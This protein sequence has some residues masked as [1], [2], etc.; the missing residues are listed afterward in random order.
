MFKKEKR[1]MQN[2]ILPAIKKN[3]IILFFGWTQRFIILSEVSYRE[4]STI[5]T[6]LICGN[7]KYSTNELIYKTETDSPTENKVMITKGEGERD[8]LGA[9][10]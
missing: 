1:Q 9:W 10:D 3:E 8:K 6:S 5:M 4:A 7:L 2:G